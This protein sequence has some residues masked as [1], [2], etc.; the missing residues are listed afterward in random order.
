MA[1]FKTL[2]ELDDDE[3]NTL[4]K[5]SSA[6]R[7][8]DAVKPLI[9]ELKKHADSTKKIAASGTTDSDELG[10]AAEELKTL[11]NRIEELPDSEARDTLLE[12]IQASR[13]VMDQALQLHD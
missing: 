10:A 6:K 9:E 12:S 11:K 4:K 1:R 2:L 3:R 13:D 5:A 7:I 8:S